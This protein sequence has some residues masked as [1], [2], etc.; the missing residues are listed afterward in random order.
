M[1]TRHLS[2]S[3]LTL[4]AAG[5]CLAQPIVPTGQVRAISA[6]STSTTPGGSFGSGPLL[7]DAPADDYGTWVGALPVSGFISGNGAQE[8]GFNGTDTITL[9]AFSMNL[10]GGNGP[11]TSAHSTMRNEFTYSFTVGSGAEYAFSCN[12]GCAGPGG[13]P[14]TTNDWSLVIFLHGSTGDEFRFETGPTSGYQLT[15]T[16]LTG[17]LAGGAY[18]LSLVGTGDVSFEAIDNGN[19][20]GGGAG[21]MSPVM[22]FHV[23]G[24]E[25]PTCPADIGAQGGA[26]GQDG[27]LDNNDF[28]VFIDYFFNH[29]AAADR[30]SQGGVPG[31]DGQWDNNDF[32]VFI[33]QFFAGC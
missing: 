22:S 5:T 3:L 12:V 19:G 29:N 27:H 16:G 11:G 23:T 18:T 9:T 24:G 20:Q 15:V 1:F 30:G 8:G 21:G 14:N 25:T 28:V 6:E 7:T 13:P 17:T 10:G 31:A 4:A 2:V 26:P 32:V 33:D